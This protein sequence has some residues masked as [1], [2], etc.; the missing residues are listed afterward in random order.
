M[1]SDRDCEQLDAYLLGDL[2]TGE[3]AR[4][5]SHLE[6]CSECREAIEEQR[7]IDGLLQSPRRAEFEKAPTIMES[8]RAVITREDRRTLRIAYSLATAAVLLIGLGWVALRDYVL[9]QK[10]HGQDV[11]IIEAQRNPTHQRFATFVSTTDAIVVPIESSADDVTIVQVYPTTET[12]R[13]QRL[14]QS[15]SIASTNRDGG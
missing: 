1:T 15:L 11:A 9:H 10:H 3:A 14:E 6:V 2:S 5:E 4:F 13:Q 7:W 8:I 12:E